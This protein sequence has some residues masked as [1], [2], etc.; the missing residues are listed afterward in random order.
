MQ[1]L[2]VKEFFYKLNTIGF[3]L[4]LV[5]LV[6]FTFLY[7]LGISFPAAFT[8]DQSVFIA[9]ALVVI[10]GLLD[11]TVV[12]WVAEMKLKRHLKRPELTGRMEG[13]AASTILKMVA[14][15]SWS[16]MSAVA[17]FFTGHV[18]FTASFLIMMIFVSFT[19]PTP[20]RLC[21]SLEL[22]GSEKEMVLKH[23][24]TPK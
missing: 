18:M 11:L 24:D 13:Y 23:L 12:H 1:F 3:I 2:T 17:F 21:R 6:V 8:D 5:P 16:L 19:W 22:Q 4:L 7:Y 10:V 20:A 15:C 9:A 14:Y